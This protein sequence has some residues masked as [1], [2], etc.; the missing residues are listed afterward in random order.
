MP[1]EGHFEA[2]PLQPFPLLTAAAI[3]K[4]NQMLYKH[5]Q[6]CAPSN[7]AVDEVL[8]RLL[9]DQVRIF[10][11]GNLSYISDA[12]RDSLE[13]HSLEYLVQH[14]DDVSV[15]RSNK[16]KIMNEFYYYSHAVKIELIF[17]MVSHLIIHDDIILF[18]L[19]FHLLFLYFLY[20]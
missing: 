4:A 19:I 16:K 17:Q 10:R 7:A 20:F 11:I 8:V 5:V 12:H 2:H 15:S 13:S 14:T 6:L 3:C 18:Y 9:K 1:V